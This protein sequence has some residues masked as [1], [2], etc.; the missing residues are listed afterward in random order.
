MNVPSQT[1]DDSMQCEEVCDLL[2]ALIHNELE[3]VES[4][5]VLRHL[6]ECKE[7]REALAQHV[8]LN[9]MLQANMPWLGKIYFSRSWHPTH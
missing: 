9:G 3:D 5:A 1:P 2:H 8:K 6:A 7:C 4:S